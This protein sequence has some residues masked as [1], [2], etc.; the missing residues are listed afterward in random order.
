MAAKWKKYQEEVADF[1][2]ALGLDAQTNVTII[3]TRTTH[4]V[5]VLVKSHQ[6]G[7]DITWIAECKQWNSRVSK[8]HVLAL[9]EI[10]IDCGADRGI[11][12]AEKGFQSGAIE[13]AGLTNVH[14]SS[15]AKI[16]ITASAEIFSMRLRDLYDRTEACRSRYWNISKDDRIDSGLRPDVGTFGYS[17]TAIVKLVED[18]L[19][20]AFRGVYPI[21]SDEILRLIA[22]ILP[23][24]FGSAELVVAAIEPLIADLEV[25]L[26]LCKAPLK[27]VRG[28]R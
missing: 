8:L 17:S 9:R 13:A 27:P 14:L 23:S 4:D 11:L 3:G 5:D 22:P 25:K 18:L 20:K 2:R 21:E 6:V 24:Q 10:V 12:L 1:F 26:S 7:F 15:L 16:R 28:R 19:T